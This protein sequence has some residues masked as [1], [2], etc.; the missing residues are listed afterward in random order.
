[1]TDAT[2]P[3]TE[4]AGADATFVSFDK[5]VED[6]A[7]L[8]TEPE[9]TPTDQTEEVQAED[10]APPA[11]DQTEEE[12]APQEASSGGK[13]VSKDAKFTLEDG[14]VISVGE[15]ARNNLYQKDYTRK[16]MEI[17]ESRKAFEAEQSKS[18]E[19]AQALEAQRDFLLAVA[20]K[21]LPQPPDQSLMQ[22]DPLGYMQAKEH[23]ETQLKL[24][25]QVYYQ[26]QADKQRAG[27]ETQ[28][29]RAQR[30]QE[31]A[32]KLLTA[33]P[34]FKDRR[35]YDSF[36]AEAGNLMVDAYGYSA[37]EL[38][39]LLEDHRVYKVL[40][41]LVLLSKARS[42]APKVKAELQ[43]KPMLKAGVRQDTRAKNTRDLQAR[44]EQ[45]RKS[46]SLE[47]GTALIERLIS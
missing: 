19:L 18:R 16:T 47:D 34:E 41:D 22:S 31:E 1:M 17:A 4:S 25:N 43:Q 39:P 35:R 8:L 3:A 28:A 15:L 21:L 5:S 30:Q 7:S 32:N 9:E 42:K 6:I 29:Q 13:F 24:I 10:G 45:L 37:E 2:T 20:P 14:T 46:G 27:E 23:Y 40:Q 36:M 44:T 11:E 33:I 26:S 38:A 12:D